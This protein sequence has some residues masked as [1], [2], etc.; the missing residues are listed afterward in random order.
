M[1]IPAAAAAGTMF[2][3][4]DILLLILGFLENPRDWAACL[5]VCKLWRGLLPLA[6]PRRLEYHLH[7]SAAMMWLSRHRSMLV[8]LRSCSVCFIAGDE[9]A[10]SQALLRLIFTSAR[11]LEV[12]S[13]D[14]RASCLR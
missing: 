14:V 8:D 12:V 4:S 6:R 3:E 11:K 2:A 7:S 1:Q 10:P 5:S 13:A 9:S